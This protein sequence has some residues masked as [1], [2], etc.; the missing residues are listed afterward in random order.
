VQNAL[1]TQ[2]RA[3]LSSSRFHFAGAEIL[4]GELEGAYGWYTVNYLLGAMAPP[5]DGQQVDGNKTVG[6]MDMGGASLEVTFFPESTP[7]DGALSLSVNSRQYSLY[8]HCYMT[9][10]DE[11]ALRRV[12]EFLVSSQLNS[13]IP[14]PHPCLQQGHEIQFNSSNGRHYQFQGAGNAESCSLLVSSLFNSSAPCRVPPC[15][16]DG[17]YQPPL[18]GEFYAFSGLFSAAEFFRLP[19]RF[20]PGTLSSRAAEFC[21]APYNSTLTADPM[22]FRGLFVARAV[23][24]GI[25]FGENATS[26]VWSDNVNGTFFGWTLGLL[27]DHLKLLP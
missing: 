24:S 5:E 13:S 21:A 19:S 27:L 2:V 8:T 17:V 26:I 6:T 22:C 23:S 3:K 9:Y 14:V 25:G 11:E 18:R 4:S 7:L 15:T 20:A 10:G 1:L 16:F 12:N